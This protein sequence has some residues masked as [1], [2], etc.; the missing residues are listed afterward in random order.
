[1]KAVVDNDLCIGC[2]LCVDNCPQVFKMDGDKA[3]VISEVTEALNESAAKAKDE[4]PV[5]AIEIN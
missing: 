4:C 3:I 1:M 2:G 5:E